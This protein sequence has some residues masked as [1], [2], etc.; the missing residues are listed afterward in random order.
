MISR[1]DKEMDIFMCNVVW[2]RKHHGF[3]KREMAKCLEIGVG[4]LNKLERGEIPPRMGC[5][6]FFAVS[7][8]FGVS[9]RNQFSRQLGDVE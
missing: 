4:T 8:R 2:L 9:L 7:A 6:I 5:K 1:T 3:S